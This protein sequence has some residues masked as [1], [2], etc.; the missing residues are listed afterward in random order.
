[1]VE[2]H[3]VYRD[4]ERRPRHL[5]DQLRALGTAT[6]SHHVPAG[7]V[8]ASRIR[9]VIPFTS[10]AGPALTVQNPPRENLTL[11]KALEIGKPGDLLVVDAEGDVEG[12]VWGGLTTLSAKVRGLAGMVVDGAVR[13]AIEIRDHAWPVWAAGFNPRAP[14]KSKFG[15]INVPITCGGAR[16]EPGDVVVADMDG[17]IV[18]PRAQVE[19]V[20]RLGQERA[21]RDTEMAPRLEQGELNYYI[22]G[23]DK[24]VREIG[25]REIEGTWQP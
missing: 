13:D 17:V 22:G 21:E 23:F 16:V 2:Q 9:P 15:A 12:A 19:E 1:M 18:V 3:I 6:I 7:N 14:G 25:V 4:I 10:V 5:I 11:N 20:A 24:N 8:M